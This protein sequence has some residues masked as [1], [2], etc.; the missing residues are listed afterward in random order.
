MTPR[1]RRGVSL[2]DHIYRIF[3]TNEFQKRTGKLHGKDSGFIQNKLGSYVY[4]Q[5]K[6]EPHFGTNIKKLSGYSPE[7]WRYRIGKYRLFFAID[8]QQKIVSV[9]TIKLRKDAY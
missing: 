7:T 8:E 5:L 4:P 9:L 1:I 3:E 2:T 6:A